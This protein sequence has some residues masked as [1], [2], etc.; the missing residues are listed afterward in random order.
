M[1]IPEAVA[2]QAELADQLQKELY[3]AEV[4]QEEKAKEEGAQE[5]Q[6][7]PAGNTDEAPAAAQPGSEEAKSKEAEAAP[8]T[9]EGIKTQDEDW[10]QRYLV[11]NGKYAAEV[12]ALHA[13]NKELKAKLAALEAGQPQAAKPDEKKPE[14]SL[15]DLIARASEEYGED[16]AKTVIALADAKATERVNAAKGEVSQ[17][18]DKKIG[19][20][21]YNRFL[22]GLELVVPD[23]KTIN[24]SQGFLQWLGQMDSSGKTRQAL[25]DEHHDALNVRKVA[26]I[27][28]QYKG[29]QGSAQDRQNEL[30]S[31][32]QPG[33]GKGG[34]QPPDNQNKN[35]KFFTQNE[36]SKFYDQVRRGEFKGREA[37]RDRLE[38]DITTAIAAGRIR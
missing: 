31:M 30:D 15:A 25:L 36:I 28:Q 4:K 8:V 7:P 5:H 12:P 16:F 13:E 35:E 3:S 6:D 21:E 18:V 26:N 14:G 9:Q 29:S 17:E 38:V 23:F 20:N 10:R 2:K 27:F 24:A 37:E 1:A 33:K 11:L 19:D 22:S 32:L 34:G